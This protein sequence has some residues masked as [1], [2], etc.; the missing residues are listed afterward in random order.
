MKILKLQFAIIMILSVQQT[1]F[2]QGAETMTGVVRI[3]T[4]ESGNEITHMELM[5]MT[6]FENENGEID[7]IVREYTIVRND[8]SVELQELDGV[9]VE[10]TGIISGDDKTGFQIEIESYTVVEE[11]T[12]ENPIDEP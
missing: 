5:V 10:A 11:E 6:E 8:L 7:S 12:E 2:A 9:M 1:L 3:T 4:D